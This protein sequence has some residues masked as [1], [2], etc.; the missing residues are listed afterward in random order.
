[1][2]ISILF[3]TYD[4]LEILQKSILHNLK[5]T[6]EVPDE[7]IWVD[8]GSKKDVIKFM[9]SIDPDVSI[10]NNENL[11]VAKG[12]N[13]GLILSTG[14]LIIIPGTDT[15]L[16]KNWIKLF[17][18]N[19]VQGIACMNKELSNK[20]FQHNGVGPKIISRSVF[21]DAGYLREDFG[22]YGGDDIE[23]GERVKAR[24]LSCIAFPGKFRHLGTEGISRM[25]KRSLETKEYHDFKFVEATQPEKLELLNHCRALNHPYYNPYENR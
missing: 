13:R 18:E 2:K 23:W 17:K 19:S 9:T 6:G 21:T 8:N 25:N 11:G 14:D 12:Y 7:I 15:L 5:N 24:G 22:L 3:L 20:T 1:M 10:L 16:P 4:R